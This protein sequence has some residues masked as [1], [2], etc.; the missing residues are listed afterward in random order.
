MTMRRQP[1]RI[2]AIAPYAVACCLAAGILV[3]AGAARG[4]AMQPMNAQSG[5]NPGA[6]AVLAWNA[7]LLQANAND[8]DPAVVSPPDQKGPART[9][10]AFAIVHAA[11]FEAVNSIDLSYTPY[12]GWVPASRGASIEAAVAQAAHDTLASLYPQQ[13][14]LFDAALAGSLQGIPPGRARQGIAVGKAAAANILASRANDGSQATMTYTPVPAPGF[15]Q[16]DP[17]HLNQGFLDPMWGQV[18]PFTMK[19]GAQFLAPG[20]VGG[21]VPSRLAFLNSTSYTEAFLEVQALGAKNSAIRTADQTEIGIF[22][23]YDGS[24][25]LGTPQRLYNQI[26]RIIAAQM[27]NTQ[28]QNA[29]LFALVNLAMGDAGIC[30]W[31]S[32]YVYQL[33]RPIVGIRQA[34]LTGNLGTPADPA[35]EP[36]GAQA[37][38]NSGTNFTPSFPSYTSGHATFGSSMFQV[39]RRYYGTDDIPFSIQSD[40]FNGVTQDANGQVRPPRTRSYLNLSQAEMENH[41]SRIYLG[42]HWRFDQD[43]GLAAGRKIGDQAIENFLHPR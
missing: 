6:D 15:H 2:V 4:Q 13:E 7:V 8:F 5:P 23:S 38:N 27:G 18:V 43:Q 32:K 9:A 24:P 34:A 30:C 12:L 33:W 28:V 11:I 19:S 14:D 26:V 3:P 37:D 42:V 40:E 25:Q 39:L 29:R 21:D 1:P 17:L 35:W 31:G 41:D 10:R 16:L 20:F 22:W 36:L